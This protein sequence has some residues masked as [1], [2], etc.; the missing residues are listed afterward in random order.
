MGKINLVCTSFIN[1]S[2]INIDDN[3]VSSDDNN[4]NI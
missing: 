3:N 2:L 1:E 4:T